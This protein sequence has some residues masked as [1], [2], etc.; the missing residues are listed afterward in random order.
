M[1]DKNFNTCP[2]C[3]GKLLIKN[4]ISDE[5]YLVC[6]DCGYS[7]KDK[8][9]KKIAKKTTCSNSCSSCSGCHG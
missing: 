3:G 5:L 4:T 9:G 7:I 1:Q 2:Y 8:S 6:P